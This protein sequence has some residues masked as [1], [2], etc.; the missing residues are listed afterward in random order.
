MPVTST[1][2]RASTFDPVFISALRELLPL[3]IDAFQRDAVRHAEEWQLR[4]RNLHAR[5]GP[6]ELRRR[7]AAGG[8]TK[9]A[10]W[11][12]VRTDGRPS[13]QVGQGK[14]IDSILA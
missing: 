8:L 14:G 4:G 12:Q 11:L 1:P 10:G 7:R 6:N 3:R 5:R 2:T 13:P 9:R